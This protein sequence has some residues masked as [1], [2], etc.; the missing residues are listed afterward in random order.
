MAK[1]EFDSKLYEDTGCSLAPKCLS[2]P[3]PDCFQDQV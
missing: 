3:F 1:A 2:C